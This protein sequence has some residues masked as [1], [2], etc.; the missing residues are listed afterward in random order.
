LLFAAASPERGYAYNLVPGMLIAGVGGTLSAV[1]LMAL[2]T[3]AV[4]APK[5][6]VATGVLITCQ[7]IGLALGV[8]VSL[9][10]LSSSGGAGTMTAFRHSFLA[11]SVMAGA[12]LICLLALTRTLP[13]RAEPGGGP[14]PLAKPV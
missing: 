13:L 3:A 11:V 8:S 9:T 4:H 12:G 5:Q 1:L 14:A 6:G 2:G 7:Q 10:V